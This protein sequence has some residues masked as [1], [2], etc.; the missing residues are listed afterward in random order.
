MARNGH[1][2]EYARTS[3]SEQKL[4][5]TIYQ[6]HCSVISAQRNDMQNDRSTQFDESVKLF[7]RNWWF[8]MVWVCDGD[9]DGLGWVGDGWP[10]GRFLGEK[11]P[12]GMR[13]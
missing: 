7:S 13:G 3:N 12:L 5:P 10:I 1:F 4:N 8:V 2:G 9:G 6:Y 11:G